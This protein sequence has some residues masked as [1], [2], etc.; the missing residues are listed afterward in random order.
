MDSYEFVNSKK[1]SELRIIA[2]NIIKKNTKNKRHQKKELL[3]SYAYFFRILKVIELNKYDIIAISVSDMLRIL[4]E[5]E[6]INNPNE[7]INCSELNVIDILNITCKGLRQLGF[8]AYK[9]KPVNTY[10]GIRIKYN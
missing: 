5:V 4:Q 3:N 10:T 1:Y 6:N 2:D 9:H 7:E 8:K